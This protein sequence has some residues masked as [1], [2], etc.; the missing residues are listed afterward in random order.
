M[1][2]GKGWLWLVLGLI[3]GGVLV[4]LYS[5]Y[6]AHG[7][8]LGTA[9]AICP[10][11]PGAVTVPVITSP[12]DVEVPF[13]GVCAGDKITWSPQDGVTSFG[14][15]VMPDPKTGEV[16]LDRLHFDQNNPTGK[17]QVLPSLPPGGAHYFKYSIS[18]NGG[19]TYDP[20][21]IMVR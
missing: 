6:K 4:G 3:V 15:D 19:Q 10:G 11:Q 21:I 13:V 9:G 17:G 2:G 18:V 8:L 7:L 16:P 5:H 14:V 12:P 1:T 20:G